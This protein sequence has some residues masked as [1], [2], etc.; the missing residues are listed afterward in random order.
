L[1]DVQTWPSAENTFLET[2]EYQVELKIVSRFKVVDHL[3]EVAKTEA[4]KSIIRLI[5]QDVLVALTEIRQAA[6][7]GD[8][9]LIVDTCNDLEKRILE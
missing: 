6:Y 9:Q 1:A 7:S 8:R 5:F 2:K 4:E 3:Y